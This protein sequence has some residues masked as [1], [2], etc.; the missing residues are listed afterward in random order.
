MQIKLLNLFL[1]Y[2]RYLLNKKLGSFQEILRHNTIYMFIKK[3]FCHWFQKK[4]F[5]ST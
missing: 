5:N 4:F 3:V 2:N 1:V